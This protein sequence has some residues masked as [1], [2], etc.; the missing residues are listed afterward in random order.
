MYLLEVSHKI[1]IILEEISNKYM[2]YLIK[3]IRCKRLSLRMCKSSNAMSA[4]ALPLI[5]NIIYYYMWTCKS[6]NAMSAFALH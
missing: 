3:N 4:F 6:S 5:Y 2:K 1:P